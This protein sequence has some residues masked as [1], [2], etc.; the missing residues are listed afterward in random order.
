MLIIDRFEADQAVI[1][2]SRDEEKSFFNIPKLVLPSDAKEGDVVEIN[3]D[4]DATEKR[5]DRI[6]ALTDDLFE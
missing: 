3:I 2:F 5:R 4:K 1:E 6:D